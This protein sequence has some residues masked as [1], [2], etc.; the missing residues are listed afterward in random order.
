MLSSSLRRVF[1][2]L[3]A[4]TVSVHAAGYQLSE[5]SVTNLGRAFSGVGLVGDDFSALGYNPAGMGFNETSGVQ[6]GLVGLGIYSKV[7]GSVEYGSTFPFG[8]DRLSGTDRPLV[9]RAL[10]SAFGQYKYND[11]MTFGLGV[12]VPY[13]L[14][15]DYSRN[16]FGRTHALLSEVQAVNISPAVAVKVGYGVTLGAALNV[17]RIDAE[18]TGAVEGGTFYF[19]GKSKLKGHDTAV[20]YSVGVTYEPVE[21][22]RLGMAYRS[23]VDHKLKGTNTVTGVP[24]LPSPPLP[25]ADINGKTG[26][27]ASIVTPQTVTFSA[28]QVINEKWSASAT[29]RWTNWGSFEDL[30]IKRNDGSILTTTKENWRDTWFSALGVD[31]K[32]NPEWTFRGGFAID[33]AAATTEYRTARIPD[34]QRYWV[35]VGASWARANWQVD[36]GYAHLFVKECTATHGAE[37]AS[38][39]KATYNTNADILGVSVQYK[40]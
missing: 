15:T 5:F 28:H 34:S 17:Q 33:T 19:G 2:I 8:V 37:G 36:A 29:V 3:L 10:P 39:F 26:V 23:E 9:A 31:Y 1:A 20:G 11:M 32:F 40:F 27:N 6:M 13:G 24:L 21:G 35:T 22:T 30:T 7:K 38:K 4:G 25:H 16:W 14:A 12:Y 18:L